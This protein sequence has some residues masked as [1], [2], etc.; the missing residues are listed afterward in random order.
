MTDSVERKL[1]MLVN[2]KPKGVFFISG[3]T[4]NDR[5]IKLA[6]G[7]GELTFSFH[8]S[9]LNLYIYSI[10]YPDRLDKSEVSGR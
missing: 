6:R 3:A 9:F 10:I 8:L 2:S 1:R 7:G 5:F 4:G